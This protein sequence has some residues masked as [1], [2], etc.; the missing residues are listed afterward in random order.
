MGCPDWHPAMHSLRLQRL[1]W[2]YWACQSLWKQTGRQTGKHSRYHM[3]SAAWQGRGALR[4]EKLSEHG[5]ARALQH[6]SSELKRSGE[7]KRPTFYTPRSETICVRPDKHL[8]C[9]KATLERLLRDGAERVWTFPNAAR[10]HLEQRL[11][12]KL[13]H[14]VTLH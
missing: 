10:C 6:I 3:W 9:S 5:Q 12:L 11:K 7:W 2:I 1:L 8:H 13:S 14:Q 4:L